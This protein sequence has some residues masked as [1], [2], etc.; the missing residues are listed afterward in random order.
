M[1]KGSTRYTMVERSIDYAEQQLK[2]RGMTSATVPAEASGQN[3]ASDQVLEVKAGEFPLKVT[4]AAG[5]ALPEDAHLFVF[6]VILTDR[7]CP[8]R[9]SAS[10]GRTSR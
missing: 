9:S 2:K 5:I 10:R 7:P 3:A 1:E 6:A 8:S 4:L